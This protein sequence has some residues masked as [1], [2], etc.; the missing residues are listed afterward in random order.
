[1]SMMRHLSK[2]L[3]FNSI[4]YRQ[5]IIQIHFEKTLPKGKTSLQRNFTSQKLH[6][7]SNFTTPRCRILYTGGCEV[8]FASEVANAVKLLAQ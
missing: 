1:M 6:C 5:K 3:S 8:C 7:V 2:I 4:T